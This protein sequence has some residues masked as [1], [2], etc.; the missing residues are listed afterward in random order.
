MLEA[1][2]GNR[3]AERV[4]LHIYHYGEVHA[5]AIADDYGVVVNPIRSQ[6]EKF[7]NAGILVGKAAGRTRLYSFNK[8]SP[9]VKPL[10]ELLKIAYES[11][12]IEERE[13]LFAARRRPR[14]KGKPVLNGI[15]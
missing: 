9:F 1:I 4:F 13:V 2:F 5:R 3:T 15:Q 8:K 11:I 6:I 10:Q 7:E 14:K 12:P